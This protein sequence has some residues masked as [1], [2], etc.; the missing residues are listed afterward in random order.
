MAL[1]G[2]NGTG[3]TTILNLLAGLIYPQ[4]GQIF[5]NGF[6]LHLESI[7]AKQHIGFLPDPAP[8]YLELTIREYLQ[9]VAKLHHI[10]KNEREIT[11]D[12]IM[13]DLHLTSYQHYLIGI[14]SKGLKQRIGIAQAMLHS[15]PVLLLDEPTQGLDPTQIEAFQL[16]LRERK[17][18]SAII[19]STHY[20]NEVEFLCDHIIHLNH[21]DVKSYDINH[22]TA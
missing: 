20:L 5:I 13:E 8:L 14:L 12:N 11:I 6:N 18:N 3:K 1:I 15:P 17:G 16:L 4:S 10:P 22:C 21:Q 7:I 2:A 19:L 9:L